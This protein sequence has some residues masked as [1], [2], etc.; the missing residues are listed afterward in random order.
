MDGLSHPVNRL[1]SSEEHG[2]YDVEHGPYSLQDKGGSW[3]C[4]LGGEVR[5]E[6]TAL[7]QA[8]NGSLD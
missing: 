7:I 6:A 1:I 5:W 8:F 2:S 4:L 3:L